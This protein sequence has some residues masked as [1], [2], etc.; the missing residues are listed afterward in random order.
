MC[1]DVHK[2][3]RNFKQGANKKNNRDNGVKF[4]V[5]DLLG[6]NHLTWETS[7]PKNN[8]TLET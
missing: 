8:Y 1:S 6:E 2:L 7:Q 4:L 3:D 5:M